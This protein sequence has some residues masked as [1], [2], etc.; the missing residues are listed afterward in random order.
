MLTAPEFQQAQSTLGLIGRVASSVDWQAYCD[1]VSR[2]ETIGPFVDPTAYL[3][4]PHQLREETTE[5]AR[6]MLK[7]VK[8]WEKC[9]IELDAALKRSGEEYD[10]S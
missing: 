6:L 4:S 10:D 5:L 8:Q 1:T 9:R 7:V 2:A 3:R